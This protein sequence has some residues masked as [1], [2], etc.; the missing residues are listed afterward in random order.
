MAKK[1]TQQDERDK[2]SLLELKEIITM[3]RRNGI[4][5]FDLEQGGM[6]LRVVTNKETGESAPSHPVVI[7]SMP[8]NPIYSPHPITQINPPS[9]DMVKEE[10]S[11]NSEKEKPK[12]SEKTTE[13]S[14]KNYYEVKAPMVGTFYKAP[15]PDA[16]PYVEVGDFITV[17]S[18]LCIVE[19]MKLMNEIKSEVRGTV[20]KV[21][22]ENGHPVEY[23]QTLFLIDKGA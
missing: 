18:V 19:A 20:K 7:H 17:D 12:E 11:V 6:R 22:V 2:L 21:C 3:I 9:L 5:E 14:E 8:P 1:I 15:A 13:E 4:L 16:P 10:I 23:G